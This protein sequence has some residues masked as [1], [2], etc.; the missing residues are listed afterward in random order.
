MIGIGMR[1]WWPRERYA[2][3]QVEAAFSAHAIFEPAPTHE[4]MARLTEQRL[5][6]L[7]INCIA[8]V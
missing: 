2:T 6:A 4:P 7:A 3:D 1:A 5:I 8:C